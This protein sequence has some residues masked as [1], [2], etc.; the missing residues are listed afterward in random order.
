LKK[1][2]KRKDIEHIRG[3]PYHPKTQ[4]KIERYHRSM[5]NEITLRNYEFPSELEQAIDAFVEY[6]NKQRY[7]EALDNMTP[8]D[9]YLGREKKIQT[10]REKIKE[11][12]L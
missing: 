10:R 6:Y 12:I 11:A 1:Y 3:A 5:K 9:V 2:L 4:G 7:H 8:E